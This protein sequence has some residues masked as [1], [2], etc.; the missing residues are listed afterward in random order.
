MA[1][2]AALAIGGIDPDM[3]KSVSG[4]LYFCGLATISSSSSYPSS[5]RDAPMRAN[6]ISAA[7]HPAFPWTHC[8][9]AI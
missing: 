9:I 8:G 2:V 7:T 1:V 3:G 4:R 5:T 6:P